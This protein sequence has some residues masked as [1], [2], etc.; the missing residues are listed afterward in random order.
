MRKAID[1]TGRRVGKLTVVSLSDRLYGRQK[2]YECKCDCGNVVYVRACHITSGHTKSCGCLKSES[3]KKVATKHGRSR[4]R[5][6]QIWYGMRK[7]CSNNNCEQ[8]KNYGGR[9]ITVCD[10]WLHDFQAFYDWAM[11]N[12]YE[13]HLTID[14]IEVNGNYSPD[15]CRWITNK[16]QQNNRRT[17]HLLTYKGETRSLKDW[18]KIVGINYST[19]KGRINVYGWSAEKALETN[20]K[21]KE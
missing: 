4:E 9:G 6:A 8:F 20:A 3:M 2:I 17:S 7:R 5:L 11:A 15:N 14:R 13:D 19:L 12:G 18:S 21:K 16:D 1:L 10:E